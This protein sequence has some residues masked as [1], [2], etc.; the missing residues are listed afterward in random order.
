MLLKWVWNLSLDLVRNRMSR[1]VQ[2]LALPIVGLV[3]LQLLF[4]QRRSLSV[5][6]WDS[7]YSIRH[8]LE[9]AAA[10]SAG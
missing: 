4:L 9:L 1:I 2:P 5:Q 10:F 6:F 3:W 8:T 7:Y